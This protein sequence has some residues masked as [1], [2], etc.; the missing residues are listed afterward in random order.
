MGN[1]SFLNDKTEYHSFAKACID[2]EKICENS[3]DACV[4]STR[5]ALECAIKWVYANDGGLTY[6]KSAGESSRLF[7]LMENPS[8]K[9]VVPK[10]LLNK[11]HTIRT[12]GNSVV[13]KN[14]S[15][16]RAEAIQC[17]AYLFDFVQWIDK[18]YGR[19]YIQRDFDIDDVPEPPSGIKKVAQVGLG[20]AAGIVIATLGGSIIRDKR[21][22]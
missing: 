14:I 13:H 16:S 11:I 15:V 20:V 12:M 3:P 7:A 22:F 9:R 8:F 2:A 18:R 17:L 1:F 19:N 6:S 4:S 5:S 10:K 21:F